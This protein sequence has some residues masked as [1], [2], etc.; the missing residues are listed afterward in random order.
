M[1]YG[2]LFA[3]LGIAGGGHAIWAFCRI[4]FGLFC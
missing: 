2:A 1:F 4:W 3:N